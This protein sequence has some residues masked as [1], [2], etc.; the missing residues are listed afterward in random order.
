MGTPNVC[1]TRV[2]HFTLEGILASVKEAEKTIG[3][4]RSLLSVV[5]APQTQM[6]DENRQRE[7]EILQ[8]LQATAD[9]E[10]HP[11]QDASEDTK[12][13]G[14]SEGAESLWTV[15]KSPKSAHSPLHT[16]KTLAT[17]KSAS[18]KSRE[19]KPVS[20]DDIL[21]D[22]FE[23]LLSTGSKPAAVEGKPSKN[24]EKAFSRSK[25]GIGT[26]SEGMGAKLCETREP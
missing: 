19:K 5:S 15:E 16:N 2:V 17:G 22:P 1:A 18:E 23:R 3:R 12:T 6:S 25:S 14:T 9:E 7:Q 24:L 4:R 11:S 26:G 13:E 8:E 20:T 21:Q 10:G